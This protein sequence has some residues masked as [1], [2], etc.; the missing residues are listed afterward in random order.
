MHISREFFQHFSRI[1]VLG[2]IEDVDICANGCS[3]IQQQLLWICWHFLRKD[4][5]NFWHQKSQKDSRS[6][7]CHDMP[8]SRGLIYRYCKYSH[9][10]GKNWIFEQ[11]PIREKN[12]KWSRT[13]IFEITV[14]KKI[15]HLRKRLKNSLWKFHGHIY[16]MRAWIWKFLTFLARSIYIRYGSK[17]AS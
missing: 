7:S 14:K 5:S 11:I 17:V 10:E 6:S 16:F 3:A 9:D 4:W 2:K 8:I 12:S 1:P 13:F 15:S